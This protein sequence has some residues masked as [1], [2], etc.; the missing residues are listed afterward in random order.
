MFHISNSK[1]LSG[2]KIFAW[3]ECTSVLKMEWL[4]LNASKS[5]R[6]VYIWVKVCGGSNLIRIYDRDKA[7]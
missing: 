2:F 1:F 4:Y 3:S 6:C 7:N 5:Y